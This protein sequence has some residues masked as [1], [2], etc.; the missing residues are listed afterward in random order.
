MGG[1]SSRFWPS[2]LWKWVVS[3]FKKKSQQHCL[4]ENWREILRTCNFEVAKNEIQTVLNIGNKEAAERGGVYAY[5]EEVV[6]VWPVFKQ[7][8][9]FATAVATI[10][11]VIAARS[12]SS[13]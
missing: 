1:K 8:P 9:C 3:L 4:P 11:G 2:L 5:R 12:P 7:R 10:D 13:P 6:E